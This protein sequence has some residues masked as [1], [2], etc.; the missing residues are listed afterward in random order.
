MDA[1]ESWLELNAN[2]KFTASES[3]QIAI[4]T[5]EALWTALRKYRECKKTSVAKHTINGTYLCTECRY[6]TIYK[7]DNYCPHCG[8]ELMFRTDTTNG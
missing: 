8:A 2:K 5:S 6:P 4:V 7:G 1:Y 3:N